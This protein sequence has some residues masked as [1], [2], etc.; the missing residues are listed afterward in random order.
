VSRRVNLGDRTRGRALLLW[1][2]LLH[3]FKLCDD[4]MRLV[5]EYRGGLR[6]TA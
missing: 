2:G 3:A 6:L 4:R 5:G 1:N